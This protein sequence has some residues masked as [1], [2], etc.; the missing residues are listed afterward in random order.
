MERKWNAEHCGTLVYHV[1]CLPPHPNTCYT[2]GFKTVPCMVLCSLL[3][4]FCASVDLLNNEML[5]LI[6]Q[7]DCA[8]S[9]K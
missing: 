5:E 7:T 2:V 8:L 9:R 3:C 4:S 6:M 1:Q